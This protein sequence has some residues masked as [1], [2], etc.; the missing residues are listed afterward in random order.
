MKRGLRVLI[1]LLVLC[2]CTVTSASCMTVL[3]VS[4]MKE[5]WD[6]GEFSPKGNEWLSYTLTDEDKTAFDK[7]L[8]TFAECVRNGDS[9]ANI[10]GALVEFDN[11][12]YH[13]STQSQI[14]YI[15]Y[16]QNLKDT[17]ARDNY[18]FASRMEADAMDA[19]M[20]VCREIDS[21]NYPYRDTFFAYWTEDDMAQMRSYTEQVSAIKKENEDLL[22]EYRELDDGSE[23]YFESTSELY[24]EL[25]L[26]NQKMANEFGF[27]SYYD[28]AYEYVYCRDYTP[29]ETEQMRTYVKELLV[30]LCKE[31]YGDFHERMSALSER[32]QNQLIEFISEDY[33]KLATPWVEQYFQS[34][35]NSMRY[36]MVD[37]LESGRV[38]YATNKN[39]QRG[40]FTAYLYEYNHPVLYFSEGYRNNITVAHEAGHYYA[41]SVQN[42]IGASVDMAEVYSQSNEFLMLAYLKNAGFDDAV[43]EVIVDY[44][45]YNLLASIIVSTMIDEFEQI[46]YEKVDEVNA[47][48]C[49]QWYDQ[50]MDEICRDYGGKD[51]VYE[52]LTDIS[53][54]WRYVT[55][56]QPIYYISYAMSGVA[57]LQMYQLASTDYNAALSAYQ[58]LVHT[59]ADVDGFLVNLV[60][61]G[62][63]TP[64]KEEAY[65]K[66]RSLYD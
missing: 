3:R 36:Y 52:Y 58:T 44:Q 27:E 28:F 61:A 18:L 1:C 46:A 10:E 11:L 49:K 57:A 30:P 17:T 2:I 66:I 63:S 35:P 53:Y 13:I 48:N 5:Q 64:L 51:F 39:A 43:Y 34:L 38:V 29:T 40:A 33:H 55:F 65:L 59:P 47:N 31:A 14:A 12:Y 26:N 4:E 56:E 21:S 42:G 54:Y 7:A 15:I 20:E 37:A 19:Y 25:V 16:N 8:T 41:L 45:L 24:Y 9:F 6:A 50:R 62:L 22:V 23:Q 32:K 60:A